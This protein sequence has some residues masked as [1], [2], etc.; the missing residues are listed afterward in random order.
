[1]KREVSESTIRGPYNANVHSRYV[2]LVLVVD[3]KVYKDLDESLD[4]VYQHCK[5]IGNIINKLYQPLNI[6]VALVGVVVWSESDEIA[7]SSNGYYALQFIFHFSLNSPSR[8]GQ[9]QIST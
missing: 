1:M 4:R 8:N 3:N 5:D 6:F 7:L 9:A 2:E